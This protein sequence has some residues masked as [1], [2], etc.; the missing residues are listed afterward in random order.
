MYAS[1]G[2]MFDRI[3]EQGI[4]G[5][6]F[7]PG[8]EKEDL[9]HALEL[10]E[11]VFVVDPVYGLEWPDQI[12]LPGF[13]GQEERLAG[14]W[15][16]PYRMCWW[17]FPAP[18]TSIEE[19]TRCGVLAGFAGS[20]ELLRAGL[21]LLNGEVLLTMG[22]FWEA[23]GKIVYGR[24][25]RS[26]IVDRH[27]RIIGSF[28]YTAKTP[29]EEGD[30]HQKNIGWI[31][32]Y[33]ARSVHQALSLMACKN[34]EVVHRKAKQHLLKSKKQRRKNA[35]LP[36]R[37]NY[38]TLRI[39]TGGGSRVIYDGPD[40]TDPAMLKAQHLCRGH[41]K[42]YPGGLFGKP[43]LAGRYWWPPHVRG[44]LEVGLVEK[45]YEVAV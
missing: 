13:P 33:C 31:W 40:S 37:Y 21:N 23:Q 20:N 44:S 42:E 3:R 45:D 16:L 35:G 39:T 27:G 5:H 24:V 41:F 4:L 17:E 1:K 26:A 6:E 14:P 36:P 22:A 2:T 38:H 11:A 19:T 10:V 43:E 15:M 30:D 7:L 28:M 32:A 34:V 18:N 29:D 8:K 12:P 9:N 25:Q